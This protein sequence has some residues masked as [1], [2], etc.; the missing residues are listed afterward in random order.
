MTGPPVRAGPGPETAGQQPEQRR[1]TSAVPQANMIH[2]MYTNRR[3]QCIQI[4]V[5]TYRYGQILTNKEPKQGPG[6]R[7]SFKFRAWPRAG[8]PKPTDIRIECSA[9]TCLCG[10]FCGSCDLPGL[11]LPVAETL[12]VAFELPKAKLNLNFQVNFMLT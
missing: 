12:A 3:N 9:D 4:R 2:T 8:P 7:H 11:R 6:P 5:N 10:L 1:A